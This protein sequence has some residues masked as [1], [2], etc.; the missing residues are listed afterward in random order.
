MERLLIIPMISSDYE[1]SFFSYYLNE[2]RI[3]KDP[4]NKLAISLNYYMPSEEYNSI[5]ILEPLNIYNRMGLPDYVYPLMKWGSSLNYKNIVIKFDNL[6]NN[7]VDKGIPVIFGEVGILNDYIKQDN[8]IEQFL[9]TLFSMSNEYE[10]ILPCLWDIPFA[11]KNYKQFY[12]DKRSKEWSDEKY[13]IIFNKIS[14]GKF[15]KSLDYYYQTNLETHDFT[16]GGFFEINIDSKKVVK[17][18]VNMTIFTHVEGEVFSIFTYLSGD[19]FYIYF[20]FEEKDGKK[21]YDGT[22]IFTFDASEYDICYFVQAMTWYEENYMII[23]NLTVQ[24][25]E[26]FLYFDYLSYKS[27]I[28]NEINSVKN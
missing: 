23:N 1:I 9:Y 10:G 24:Y 14:K 22:T 12:F 25:E 6:K 2:Y 21:Q 13:G 16:S 5:N 26:T 19:S 20:D 4:H 8:S 27:D 28:L 18:I 17:I 7:F 15:I 11:S 3:P